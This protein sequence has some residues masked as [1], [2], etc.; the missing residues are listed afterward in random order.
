L[1]VRTEGLHVRTEVVHVRTEVWHVRTEVL[2]SATETFPARANFLME[3]S[4][5]SKL[6]GH[7]VRNP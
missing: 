3:S 1:H 7:F 2:Q 6:S 5:N 4:H